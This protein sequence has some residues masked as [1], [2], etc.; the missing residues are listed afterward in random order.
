MRRREDQTRVDQSSS[1]N[2]AQV[3]FQN[4]SLF[5][6]Q[7]YCIDLLCL[8]FTHH[9]GIL[10]KFRFTPGIGNIEGPGQGIAAL[11]AAPLIGQPTPR[12]Y[13]VSWLD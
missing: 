6:D 7:L 10:P 3:G 9:P 5:E 1:A 13:W 12:C 11:D 2:V 4:G 8:Q